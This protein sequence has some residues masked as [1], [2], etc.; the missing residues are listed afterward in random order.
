MEN[1]VT[2]EIPLTR[3]LVALVDAG[4]YGRFARYRWQAQSRR[5]EC[6]Y[7]TRREVGTGRVI[8]M[9]RE[10][11]GLASDDL[12]VGDHIDPA[13]TLDNRRSNLRICTAMQNNR[14]RRKPRNNT[15]GFKGVSLNRNKWRALLQIGKSPSR[16]SVNLGRFDTPEE[17]YAA[18]CEGANRIHGEFA[19]VA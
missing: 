7:A 8:Y 3:G 19:R 10:V 12:R 1:T 6:F 4:D 14:N 5:G 17:A 15:S 13:A 11:L 18:Y 16:T 9:H 2:K